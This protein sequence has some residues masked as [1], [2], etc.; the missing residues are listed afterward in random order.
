MKKRNWKTTT[1]G[2]LTALGSLFF[3]IAPAIDDDPKTQPDFQTHGTLIL[4]ALAGLGLLA[5]K[6]SSKD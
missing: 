5:A 4:T 6:D 1:A 3:L 2:V